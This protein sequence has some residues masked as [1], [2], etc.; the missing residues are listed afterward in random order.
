MGNFLGFITQG[1]HYV[2][3]IMRNYMPR[4]SIFL[5]DEIIVALS[6][7]SLWLFRDN[8]A[9]SPGE[10]F[11]F[12]F[13]LAVFLFSASSMIFRTY[14]GVVRFSTMVDL[15]KLTTAT[16]VASALYTACALI[17][18]N[19]DIEGEK[20]MEF[21]YWFPIVMGMMVIAGQFIFRFTVR[22][23]FETLE[24]RTSNNNKTRAFILGSEYDSVLLGNNLL[25]DRSSPYLPV[26]FIAFKSNQVGKVVSGIPILSSSKGLT[27][28]MEEFKVKTLL[29]YKSQLEAMPKEFY[30]RC[31]VE[32][33]ELL[34]VSSFI[35]YDENNGETS[36]QINKIKIEDLLGRNA[37]IMNK[38]KIEDQF[39][40]QTILITGAAGSIGSEMARQISQFN[41]KELLLVDQAE[42]PLNDLWLELVGS[43][44]KF[45]IKPIIANVTSQ[46]K[47]R[48][49]F[50]IARPSMVFHAA[51][52]KHVPM[53]EFHPS[54]AVVTNVGGTKTVADLSVEYGVKRFVM[55]STDK[56]VNPTN[57]MGATKRAA[58]MYIQSLNKKQKGKEN[59]TQFVTTRFGNV[60]GSSGSVV[61][62]FKRQIEAGGPL[63]VTHKDITRYF[64]TIP[65]ACSLVLEAGCTGKG[66]EIY[67]FDMGEAVKIYDLAEKMIRLSGK[68]PHKDIKIVETGLRPGEKLFEELLA[69]AENTIPTYHKKVMIAKVQEC[70]YDV[71]APEIKDMLYVSNKYVYP[72][73][74][75]RLLK[76]LV[77]EFKSQNSEYEALDREL[78]EE[79]ANK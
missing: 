68:I 24:Y 61:P 66:G 42:T 36:P 43:G 52:Y 57:V 64:M 79:N 62:L 11:A 73:D 9:A 7:V 23:V 54:T 2:W 6:F 60:L 16:I 10:F 71:V 70:D 49:I 15:K 34:M 12:K 44:I 76:K 75:V 74:V 77:P 55:I 21:N 47:M 72:T 5:F 53:M 40:G 30:E 59:P 1:E 41:C 8:I 32:G 69:T 46:I 33:L 51:A 50:E 39:E 28:H 35:K 38:E 26:A 56:A 31:I 13:F 18:T 17:I 65:E 29:L 22:S 45:S 78:E 58:E 14:H 48:Q 19:T 20:Q 4:W 37:I 27:K 25:A 63:T 67:I 3:G